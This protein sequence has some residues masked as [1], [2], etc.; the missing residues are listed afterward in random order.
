MPN[1]AADTQQIPV[2]TPEAQHQQVADNI[3]G[4][5]A[6]VLGTDHP[7]AEVMPITADTPSPQMDQ[8]HEAANRIFLDKPG[9]E[10]S[11]SFLKKMWERMKKKHP[12]AQVTLKED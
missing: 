2:T 3:A 12:D 10:P 7:V 5:L 4:N 1:D 6:T 8:F 9:F 11:K